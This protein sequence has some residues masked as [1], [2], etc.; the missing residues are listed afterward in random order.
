MKRSLLHSL[1]VFP[2]SLTGNSGYQYYGVWL[3]YYGV[4]LFNYYSMCFHRTFCTICKLIP[5]LICMQDEF[6]LFMLILTCL[7]QQ[8]LEFESL[9]CSISPT[10]NQDVTCTQPSSKFTQSKRLVSGL[11]KRGIGLDQTDPRFTLFG[12]SDEPQRKY[13]LTCSHLSGIA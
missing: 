2:F 1:H 4:R 5:S 3:Q 13:L 6:T 7:T 10:W 12:N 8:E 11:T 9:H